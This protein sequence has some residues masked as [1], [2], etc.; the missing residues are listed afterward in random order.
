MNDEEIMERVEH[1]WN[2]LDKSSVMLLSGEGS[3]V[4]CP[5]CGGG[6]LT[7]QARLGGLRRIEWKCLSCGWKRFRV[8]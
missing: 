7:Y 4:K 8:V 5:N 2:T 3:V 6:I 1:A